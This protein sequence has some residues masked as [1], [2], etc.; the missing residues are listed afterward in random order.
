MI[1]IVTQM[2][3]HLYLLTEL[4]KCLKSYLKGT[5]SM[6]LSYEISETNLGS[7][8]KEKLN[9]SLYPGLVEP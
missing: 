9:T 3:I 8:G 6:F 1:I 5:K 2:K 7:S 4:F